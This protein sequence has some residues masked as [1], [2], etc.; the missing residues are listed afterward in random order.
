MQHGLSVLVSEM[1]EAY[2]VLADDQK[3]NNKTCVHVSIL[4]KHIMHGAHAHVN[5][6]IF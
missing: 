1:P 2:T 4:C 6:M 3:M 5:N